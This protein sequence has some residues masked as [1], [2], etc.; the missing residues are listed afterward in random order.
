MCWQTRRINKRTATK[1]KMKYETISV[2]IADK[3]QEDF[4]FVFWKRN[5]R[6]SYGILVIMLIKASIYDNM[7]WCYILLF[8]VVTLERVYLNIII[9][10]MNAHRRKKINRLCSQ[11]H[12]VVN[13]T[14]INVL[15][16]TLVDNHL[17]KVLLIEFN[18]IIHN[19]L[20]FLWSLKNRG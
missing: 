13:P 10:I 1:K 12:A 16:S 6:I 18:K 7:I 20:A 5:T 17:R 11:Q 2:I 15:W 19:F 9:I 4:F 8:W 3:G 14:K